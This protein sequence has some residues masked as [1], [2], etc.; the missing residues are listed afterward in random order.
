MSNQPGATPPGFY[1]AEGGRRRYWD[2]EAWTDRYED[3]EAAAGPSAAPAGRSSGGLRRW[4][5]PAATISAFTALII[6]IGIAG[7]GKGGG[8]TGAASTS[9]VT[10]TAAAST[11]TATATVTTGPTVTAP[12]VT[13][14][15]PPVTVTAPAGTVTAPPV[16]V[17]P[18]PVTVT[19]TPAASESPAASAAHTGASQD[20][21]AQQFGDKWPL[22]V[23]RAIIGCRPLYP[24]DVKIVAL[25]LNDAGTLYGLNGTALG[26][27]SREFKDPHPIWK[28][29]FDISPLQD[30]A[31]KLC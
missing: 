10:A 22:T 25:F 29:G 21:T 16:T 11:V 15:L 20:V 30:A 7:A 9:T 24:P 17:T 4:L 14:A 23:D 1:P 2:G 31:R 6:G 19:Y 13:V 12:P 28:A 27:V 18:P 3:T 8:T 26:L 5:L